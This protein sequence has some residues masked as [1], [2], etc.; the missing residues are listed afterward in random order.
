MITVDC[1]KGVALSFAPSD[2]IQEVIQGIFILLNTPLGEVP[3]YREFGID[4]SYLHKPLPVAKT[5]Y[6]AAVT[7]AVERYIPGVQVQ[8][9]HFSEASSP[10]GLSPILEVSIRE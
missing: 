4:A 8:R 2:H 7:E 9:V 5:M 1:S 3:C 10:S 6:A